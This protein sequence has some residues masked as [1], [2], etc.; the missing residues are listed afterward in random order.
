M[1]DIIIIG[2]VVVR[3]EICEGDRCWDPFQSCQVIKYP[4]IEWYMSSLRSNSTFSL[5]SPIVLLEL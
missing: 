1:N 2:Y 4:Y 3:D 5:Y